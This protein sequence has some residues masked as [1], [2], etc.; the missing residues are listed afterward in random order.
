MDQIP[1]PDCVSIWLLA[2]ASEALKRE[3]VR[4]LIRRWNG[5]SEALQVSTRFWTR[6]FDPEVTSGAHGYIQ[7]TIRLQDAG[8]TFQQE[9]R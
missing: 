8:L 5:M 1:L 9:H 6:D 7:G 2:K 4:A 3:V